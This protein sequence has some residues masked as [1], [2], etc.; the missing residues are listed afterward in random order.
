MGQYREAAMTFLAADPPAALDAINAAKSAGNKNDHQSFTLS[1]NSYI[2]GYF[3]NVWL[4]MKIG[5]W[6]WALSIA[7][8]FETTKPLNSAVSSEVDASLGIITQLR[9]AQEIVTEF[10]EQLEQGESA[11]NTLTLSSCLLV[12]TSEKGVGRSYFL[13]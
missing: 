2:V 6:Q 1:N 13:Q 11:A 12:S 8:R 9:V 4:L 7:G 3:V 5:D 10:R